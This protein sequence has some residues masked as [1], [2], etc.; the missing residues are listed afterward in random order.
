MA[1]FPRDFCVILR[2][3]FEFLQR[4]NLPQS[5]VDPVQSILD[6]VLDK[7]EICVLL[8]G[9]KKAN[10]ACCYNEKRYKRSLKSVTT[11]FIYKKSD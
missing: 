6:C 10:N 9:N 3:F 7:N 11:K 2:E 8:N 1:L 5:M 4:C